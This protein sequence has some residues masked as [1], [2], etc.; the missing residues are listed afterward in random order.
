ME[1]TTDTVL[2][3][4]P[5]REMILRAAEARQRKHQA[6]REAAWAG[7]AENKRRRNRKANKVARASRKRNR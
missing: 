5:I 4:A 7:Y 6:G 1:N 2:E 3:V